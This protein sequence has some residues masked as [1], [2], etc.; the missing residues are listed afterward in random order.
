MSYQIINP[1]FTL[2]F[3]SM[4]RTESE[5]YYEW[6]L[7]QIPV[8]VNI[9]ENSI[10]SSS[11]FE[12]WEADQSEGS[13]NQLGRWFAQSVEIRPRTLTEIEKIYTKGPDWFRNVELEEK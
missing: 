8:R 2:D 3:H 11:G 4:S 9:L 10:H 7:V 1:P 6:F 5:D 12:Y 13:L